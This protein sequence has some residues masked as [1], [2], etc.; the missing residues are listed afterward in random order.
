MI[1][2]WELFSGCL[3]SEVTAVRLVQTRERSLIVPVS[4]MSLHYEPD[5]EGL[6]KIG[7]TLEEVSSAQ[8]SV[9][10]SLQAEN[11]SRVHNRYTSVLQ[12]GGQYLNWSQVK[13]F[14][15]GEN[16]LSYDALPQPPEVR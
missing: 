10:D 8:M 15:S 11:F 16:G 13:P 12:G 9:A 5:K 4:E 14:S 7:L 3:L 1:E 6:I 2:S